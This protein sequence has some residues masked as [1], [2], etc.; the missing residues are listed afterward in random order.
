VI[1]VFAIL[2]D[3]A[4]RR[5]V[6]RRRISVIELNRSGPK[7]AA[8]ALLAFEDG[9]RE[10]IAFVK[11]TSDTT[12][13]KTLRREH[14]N[15]ERLAREGDE[16]FR[17]TVPAPLYCTEIG[18]LTVLA[19]SARS[20]TR[21]K[22]FPPDRYFGS[23]RFR[24]DYARSLR[25]LLQFHETLGTGAIEGAGAAGTLARYRDSHHVS[26]QLAALLHDA[27]ELLAP[28][29]L[30]GVASHGDYCTANVLLP[31]GGGWF[32]V[33][34]EYPLDA[35]WPLADLLYFTCSTWCVP[36]AKSRQALVRNFEQLFFEP[37]GFS[38]LIRD[39]VEHYLEQLALGPELKLPLSVVAWAA[40]A[41]RK[42]SELAGTA[43]DPASHMP[44]ILLQDEA[45]LNLEILA[46]NRERYLR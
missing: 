26:T 7:E 38:E 24:D 20:G 5:G 23:R 45:C 39:A 2:E 32:V 16:A 44:L 13:G 8:V 1:D 29:S 11:A 22:D 15:L 9:G 14:A 4:E 40:F 42:R 33:D 34:W 37:H 27:E 3:L 46:E 30:P 10:P 21:M 18:E 43:D 41:N 31:E 35:G 25:W 17:E 12:R 6:A 28:V 19:T 36:Y